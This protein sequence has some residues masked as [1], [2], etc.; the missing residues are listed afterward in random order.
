MPT[1]A[2][3]LAA[4]LAGLGAAAGCGSPCSDLASKICS[5]QSTDALVQACNNKVSADT[6]A[7]SPSS[8]EQDK[9]AALDKTC[10]CAALA[11][12]DLAACGL[13]RDPGVPLGTQTCP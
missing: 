1:R 4:F 3:T 9:C 7:S 12:G 11:C 8:A 6:F 13:A 10:T 2:L 5:C